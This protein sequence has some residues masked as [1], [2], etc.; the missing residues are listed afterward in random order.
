MNLF[1]DKIVRPNSE[2]SPWCWL[3]VIHGQQWTTFACLTSM[4]KL[5]IDLGQTSL[6]DHAQ[7]LKV[8]TMAPA[9]YKSA[10]VVIQLKR[11]H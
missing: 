7:G 4:I 9:K 1:K 6:P 11:I 3:A 8:H 10:F 2:V 5:R